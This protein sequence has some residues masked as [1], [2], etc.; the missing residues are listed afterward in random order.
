LIWAIGE[1]IHTVKGTE[2]DDIVGNYIEQ[3]E[4]TINTGR[5]EHHQERLLTVTTNSL[6]KIAVKFKQFIPKVIL[7]YHK[8]QID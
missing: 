2:S 4:I 5:I 7:I 6:F 1:S 8:I 3:L